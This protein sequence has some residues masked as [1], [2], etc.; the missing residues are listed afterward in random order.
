MISWGGWLTSNGASLNL[1]RGVKPPAMRSGKK[2]MARARNIKPGFFKNEL[3]TELSAFDRLLFIGLWCLG[4]REGRLENR[5]RRIKMELFPCDDYDVVAGLSEL[6]RMGF[7]KTYG[8]QLQY[9]EICNFHKHQSPHG[10][11]KDSDIPD[12][13]GEITV[14]PRDSKGCVLGKKRKNNVI[15]QLGDVELTKQE[16]PDSLIPDSLIPDTGFTEKEKPLPAKRAKSF[17]AIGFLTDRGVA[18]ELARDWLAVRK[19]K[20]LAP[21]LTA[22]EGVE[23]NILKSGYSFSDAIRICCEKGWAGFDADWLSKDNSPSFSKKPQKFDPTAYVNRNK[24]KQDDNII[25]IN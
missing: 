7:I 25:D 17:D 10:T 23:R 3:L 5:P 18:L 21:T 13:F 19:G 1:C 12:E 9:I 15:S 4:D 14:H 2:E 24:V 6:E 20:K 16:R 11:E 22:F 8:D